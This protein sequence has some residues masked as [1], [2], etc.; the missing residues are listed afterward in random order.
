MPITYDNTS[1]VALLSTHP[2]A[3]YRITI[4]KGY[5]SALAFATGA[6][7]WRDVV[8]EVQGGISRSGTGL[9]LGTPLPSNADDVAVIEV[10]APSAPA[11]GQSVGDLVSAADSASLSA[12]VVRVARLAPVPVAGTTAAADREAG[13]ESEQARAERLTPSPLQGLST[14]GNRLSWSVALGIGAVVVIVGAVFARNA[15][16]IGRATSWGDSD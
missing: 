11:T 4:A 12:R 9:V 7:K 15:R 5:A 10:R 14:F 2:R 16:E 3:V 1:A 13:R 8:A 6:L